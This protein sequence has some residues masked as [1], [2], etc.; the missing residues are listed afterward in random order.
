MFTSRDSVFS[1][2]KIYEG[3]KSNNWLL[4]IQINHR[5]FPSLCIGE[6]H[7]TVLEYMLEQLITGMIPTVRVYYLFH[8]Q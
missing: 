3:G 8:V 6:N 4:I 2:H 7:A 5:S 1:I